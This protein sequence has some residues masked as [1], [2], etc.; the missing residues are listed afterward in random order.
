MIS[1]VFD[2]VHIEEDDRGNISKVVIY[3]FKS[4]II[5]ESEIAER[6]TLHK[7]QLLSYRKAV[8]KILGIEERNIKS[9]LVF[10]RLCR[11][12]EVTAD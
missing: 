1:G 7:N 3:D 9:F 10:T 8:S 5:E 2:R 4:D 11:L 12:Q 6:T